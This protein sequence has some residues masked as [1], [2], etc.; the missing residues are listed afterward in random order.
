MARR[1]DVGSREDMT[2]QTFAWYAVPVATTA[3][4]V[5]TRG[6]RI[7]RWSGLWI[8][9]C[10]AWWLTAAGI[11]MAARNTPL[12]A[13]STQDYKQ[14]WIDGA[15]ATQATVDGLSGPLLTVVICL[16]ISASMSNKKKCPPLPAPPAVSD[17]SSHD[18]N[19]T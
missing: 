11:R 13:N 18:S 4:M 1:K 2:L 6:M 19:R 5:A 8:L 14:G 16:A 3:L 15:R 10:Y 12:P 7:L 17:G 9:L